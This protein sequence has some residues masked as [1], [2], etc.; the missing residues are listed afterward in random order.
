[1]QS[2]EGIANKIES[3]EIYTIAVTNSPTVFFYTEKLTSDKKY[4]R[5]ALGLHPELAAERHKEVEQFVK[6]ISKTRYI[7][8]IGLDNSNKTLNDYKLQKRVFEKIV[9]TCADAGNKI[10][11]IHSRKAVKDVIDIIGMSFP[12]KIIMHWY[13]DP[14]SYLQKAINFGYNFSINYPMLVSTSGRNIIKS[15]PIER[16]LIETDGPVTKK[17]NEVFTPLMAENIHK[18]LASLLS[19]TFNATEIEKKISDNFNRLLK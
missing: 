8:E 12:G 18:E 16:L 13:S 3:Q 4:I 9:L 15:I 17:G 10:L 1:M 5:P 14:G 11:T 7:G 2:P 19:D 6:M